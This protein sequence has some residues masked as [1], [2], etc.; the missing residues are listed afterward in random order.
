MLNARHYSTCILFFQCNPWAANLNLGSLAQPYLFPWFLSLL[1]C[2]LM[3]LR[4]VHL[5]PVIY[6]K[7]KGHVIFSNTW[8]WASWYMGKM[9]RLEFCSKQFNSYI[10]MDN[11][12]SKQG[13]TIKILDVCTCVFLV[14]RKTMT[15]NWFGI[16]RWVVFTPAKKDDL[17]RTGLS[18]VFWTGYY[19]HA[20]YYS[21]SIL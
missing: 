20:I 13:F 15:C 10:N 6:F 18:P 2:W 9:L 16:K 17:N 19:K 4:Y 3:A 14:L 8:T 5:R 11:P 21:F 1:G 12:P 7:K